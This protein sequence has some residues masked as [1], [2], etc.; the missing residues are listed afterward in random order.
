[1]VFFVAVVHLSTR[2]FFNNVISYINFFSHMNDVHE[3]IGLKD[4]YA[5]T[6]NFNLIRAVL[7]VLIL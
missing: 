2:Y 1:M 5:S 4:I 6:L 3:S 7:N